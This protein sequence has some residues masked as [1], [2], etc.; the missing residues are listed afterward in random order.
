MKSPVRMGWLRY[1]FFARVESEIGVHDKAVRCVEWLAQRSL[2]ATGSWDG[3]L[4]LWD[5][6]MRPVRPP[7]IMVFHPS[8]RLH[9]TLFIDLVTTGQARWMRAFS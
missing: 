4:R 9:T 6:R 8:S 3:T 7:P 1:N 5:P 2:I